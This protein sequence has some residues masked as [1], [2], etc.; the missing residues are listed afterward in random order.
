MNLLPFIENQVLESSPYL[1][2]IFSFSG[3][4]LSSYIFVAIS[5][6]LW[7]FFEVISSERLLDAIFWGELGIVSSIFG[8]IIYADYFQNYVGNTYAILLLVA[9]AAEAGVG[10]LVVLETSNHGLAKKN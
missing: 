1:D 4:D 8:M 2:N 6:A 3:A 9:A 10:M 5:V 7:A